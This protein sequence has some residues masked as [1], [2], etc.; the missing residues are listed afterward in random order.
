MMEIKQKD[1]LGRLSAFTTKHGEIT[2]PTI[3]PV[4]NPKKQIISPKSMKELFKAELI[5]TNAYIDIGARHFSV[6]QEYDCAIIM[7][8]TLPTERIRYIISHQ[9]VQMQY[10]L[11]AHF[12]S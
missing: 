7:A 6:V 10:S 2:L 12:N 1:G 3:A 4:I 8:T 9:L 11:P 5:I